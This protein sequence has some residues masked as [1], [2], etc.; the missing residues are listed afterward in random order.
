MLVENGTRAAS[1]DNEKIWIMEVQSRFD[2][3][4]GTWLAVFGQ[5][6]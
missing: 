6:K 1:P 4:D 5:L 2:C 3:I